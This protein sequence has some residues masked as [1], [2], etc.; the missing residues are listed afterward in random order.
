M[1]FEIQMMYAYMIPQ[2]DRESLIV[3]NAWNHVLR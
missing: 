3:D 1:H 2:Q